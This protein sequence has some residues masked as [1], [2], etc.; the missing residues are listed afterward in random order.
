MCYFW[1]FYISHHMTL[2]KITYIIIQLGGNWTQFPSRVMNCKVILQLCKY[3]ILH[4]WVVPKQDIFVF[5][6][7]LRAVH[8]CSCFWVL[9]HLALELLDK[10]Y[11]LSFSNVGYLLLCLWV[12]CLRRHWI[13]SWINL[14]LIRGG[15][16]MLFYLIMEILLIFWVLCTM[17]KLKSLP[18]TFFH[19]CKWC[20]DW[21]HAMRL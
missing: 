14:E 10:H 2:D 9:L 16:C 11:F 21:G 19:V 7:K 6:M 3:I 13:D 20:H 17:C 8:G 12:R 4:L 1:S 5:K 15:N 18:V